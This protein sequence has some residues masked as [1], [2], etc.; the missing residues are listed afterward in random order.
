[1]RIA[2]LA[3]DNSDGPEFDALVADARRVAS[4]H[5]TCHVLV[6]AG[7]LFH[8]KFGGGHSDADALLLQAVEHVHVVQVTAGFGSGL[9]APLHNKR[10]ALEMK[11]KKNEKKKKLKRNEKEMKKK[12]KK[13]HE[14]KKTVLPTEYEEQ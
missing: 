6:A 7:G 2:T 3:F 10:R 9:G 13:K 8:D 11:K 4:V 14:L 12:K 1:M 5:H